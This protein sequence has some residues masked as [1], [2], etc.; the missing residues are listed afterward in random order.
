MVITTSRSKAGVVKYLRLSMKQMLSWGSH[1][2]E[3]G[4]DL[5]RGRTSQVS[6]SSLAKWTCSE[7]IRWPVTLKPK[8][9][10]LV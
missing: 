5:C 1:S 2:K 8:K 7:F 9:S 10:Q 6:F 4:I 3:T